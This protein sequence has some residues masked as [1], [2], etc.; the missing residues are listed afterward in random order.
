M[1]NVLPYLPPGE[2]P[3]NGLISLRMQY[4]RPIIFVG[5]H[6]ICISI[7]YLE[8]HILI[9]VYVAQKVHPLAANI[10]GAIIDRVITDSAL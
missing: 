3:I 8:I 6:Y 10:S 4:G 1:G 2:L 5:R 9:N 7:I